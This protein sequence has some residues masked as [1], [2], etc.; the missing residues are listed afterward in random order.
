MGE[1]EKIAGIGVAAHRNAREAERER[2]LERSQRVFGARRRRCAVG[3]QADAVAA[4]DLLA[5]QI[6][7]MAKQ[8]ADRRAEHM[9]DIQWISS[10]A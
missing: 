5:R 7:H 4:R 10:V 6:E 8:A 1:R 3:D 2:R 9:Q